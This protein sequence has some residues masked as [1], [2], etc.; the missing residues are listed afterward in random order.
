MLSN[1]LRILVP[2]GGESWEIGTRQKIIWESTLFDDV[3]IKL[4]KGTVLFRVLEYTYV[5]AG[6]YEWLIPNDV[7][8]SDRYK[9]RIFAKNNSAGDDTSDEFFSIID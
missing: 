7:T 2:N 3:E 8:V 6:I 5:N 9:V 4:Y 1:S